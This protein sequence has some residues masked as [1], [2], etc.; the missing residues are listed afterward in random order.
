MVTDEKESVDA[1]LILI[2]SASFGPRIALEK[3]SQDQIW[4]AF[5]LESPL[6]SSF[7]TT[8]NFINWTASYR[9]D[10]TIVAPY[11]KWVYFDESVKT[12][13][14]VKNYAENKSKKVA[15]FVSNCGA[16]NNRLEY[17]KELGTYIDVDIF[18]SCGS[19]SCPKHDSKNCMSRLLND[20][21]KFYLAFENSNCIDYIT[22]K[23]FVNGLG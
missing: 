5:Q 8:A 3:R 13:K 7:S 2:K 16:S 23:F 9:H 21:Y 6:H 12:T 18:G 1:D 11:E 22:E 20:E 15:M 19:H 4:L 10:S 14:Q 17:A